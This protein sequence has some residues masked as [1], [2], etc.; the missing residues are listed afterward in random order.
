M[1]HSDSHSNP[2]AH[3]GSSI[4]NTKK[5][6]N[7]RVEAPD[8]HSLNQARQKLREKGYNPVEYGED[9]VL[10]IYY[11][12]PKPAMVN[13][14]G[15]YTSFDTFCESHAYK[16]EVKAGLYSPEGK[17]IRSTSATSEVKDSY[18]MDQS[19]QS[20]VQKALWRLL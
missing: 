14:M 15:S 12:T 16:T 3:S 2:S 17:Q 9:A 19:I 8:W 1:H 10:T 5:I 20:T 13:S 18:S 11:D 4:G 6:K 7:I